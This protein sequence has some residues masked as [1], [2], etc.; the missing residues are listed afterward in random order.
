MD[1]ATLSSSPD[2]PVFGSESTEDGSALDFLAIRQKV[3]AALF[4][5]AEMPVAIARFRVL[6]K[7]GSGAM[8]TV[9]SAWDPELERRVAIKVLA[10][11]APSA[12]RMKREA[13]ALAR[14][15]HPNVVTVHEV[16]NVGDSVFLAMEFVRGRTLGGLKDDGRAAREKIDLYLQAAEG[17]AAAHK[18]GLVHRDFK[19]ENVMVGEDGRVRVLDFGL[20]RAS[21][22]VPPE[23]EGKAIEEMPIDALTRTGALI[24]TPAYMAPEQLLGTPADARSD[25]FAWCVSLWE[26]LT[27]SRPWQADTLGELVGKISGDEPAGTKRALPGALRR[28]LRRGLAVDPDDRW[29][30]MQRLASEVRRAIR[31]RR[32]ALLA[33][34]GVAAVAALGIFTVFA[35]NNAAPICDE[36]EPVWTDDAAAALKTTHDAVKIDAFDASIDEWTARWTDVRAAACADNTEAHKQAQACVT[37]L[38]T[39]LQGM[40][41]AYSAEPTSRFDDRTGDYPLD[42]PALCRPDGPGTGLPPVPA[43]LSR[44]IARIRLALEGEFFRRADHFYLDASR[45]PDVTPDA[46]ATGYAPL[47]AEARFADAVRRRYSGKFAEAEAMAK[48]AIEAAESVSHDVIIAKARLLMAELVSSSGKSQDAVAPMLDEAVRAVERISPERGA[49]ADRLRL[50]LAM[51]LAGVPDETLAAQATEQFE[52]ALQGLPEDTGARADAL[53]AFAR[54]LETMGHHSRAARIRHDIVAIRRVLLDAAGDGG[55]K[56]YARSELAHALARTGRLEEA[57]AMQLARDGELDRIG[58]TNI[59]DWSLE[60]GRLDDAEEAF[61]KML[62][63]PLKRSPIDLRAEYGLASVAIARGDLPAAEAR[64]AAALERQFAQFIAQQLAW[65]R[66]IQGK[67]ELALIPA[68]RAY[69]DERTRYEVGDAGL[70]DSR[71]ALAA[72]LVGARAFDDVIEL[73]DHDYVLDRDDHGFARRVL[74]L[75]LGGLERDQERERELEAAARALPERKDPRHG[76]SSTALI[77]RALVTLASR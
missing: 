77:R 2:S 13:K 34:T 39:Q 30:D 75:A 52:R 56:H 49:M 8:G 37:D 66:I 21:G 55:E 76:F 6:E 20:A 67:H 36:L 72:A 33:G 69:E 51:L 65:I 47:I 17:L 31:R 53:E 3:G 22:T 14:L 27:G 9:F 61:K 41:A 68:R 29:P 62:D 64:L 28:V 32:P 57:I 19:P 45:A 40:V 1:H 24:G 4:P 59:G 58:L 18:A 46:E 7:L 23:G 48:D 44:E 74:A 11:H 38:H 73:L 42:D 16:G 5:G 60:L 26:A 10:W 54:H 35:G 25:Q 50:D 70:H 15:S 63:L 12:K 43:E 71:L